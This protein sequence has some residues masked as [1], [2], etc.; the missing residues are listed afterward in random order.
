MTKV[1]KPAGNKLLV[2][3]DKVERKTAA[4]III[5]SEAADK[6]QMAQMTGTVVSIGPWAFHDQPGPWCS[7]GDRVKF[8]KYAGFLHKLEDEDYRVMHDLDIIMVEGDSDE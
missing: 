1:W 2:K 7:I 4:G 5:A 8:S 6:E 3:V